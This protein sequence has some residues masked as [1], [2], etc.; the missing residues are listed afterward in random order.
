MATTRPDS[1]SAWLAHLERVHPRG[2]D[3]GLARV[4]A[5]ADRLAVRPPAPLCFVVG[6]TNGKGSTTTAIEHI[7]RARGLRVGATFS[8]HLVRFNERIRLAGKL[9]D[10]RL[11]NRTLEECDPPDGVTC[12]AS[13]LQIPNA[14]SAEPRDQRQR[15]DL[16][17][18][19]RSGV[20]LD[21]VVGGDEP[22]GPSRR[23]DERW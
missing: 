20:E 10:T 22:I 14:Q 5:V 12:N 8:P 9:V 11:L 21:A 13:C 3:M 19:V 15:D 6:G 17:H 16:D 18:R 4:A 2:I 1:L 7:L 23:R